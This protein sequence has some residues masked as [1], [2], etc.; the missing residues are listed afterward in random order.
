MTA[1]R[2]AIVAIALLAHT[3]PA[4]GASVSALGRLEPGNGVV[5]LSGPS[6]GSAVIATLDVEEGD[7]VEA[8]QRLATLDR[9]AVESAAVTQRRAELA[10]VEQRLAR[11]SGLRER[12]ASSAAKVEDAE[13]ERRVALAAL[14]AAQAR[15]AMEE[16]RAPIAGQILQIHARPGERIGAE[17]FLALGDT[18]NMMTVAEVYETEVAGLEAGQ[19]ARVT[20]PALPEDIP[21]TVVRI[22]RWIARQDVLGTDPV[23]KVDSRVVEVR[24]RLEPESER[25]KALVA[26]LTNLQVEVEIER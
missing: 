8:G 12:S 24:I 6:S 15:L 17:G 3:V 16:L 2:A 7:F 22:G 23:S 19:R 18:R 25:A 20:S 9:Y 21:G 10:L 13:A 26:S 4:F 11:L 1:L 14:G 5:R